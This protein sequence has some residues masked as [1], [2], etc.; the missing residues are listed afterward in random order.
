MKGRAFTV[1]GANA[2]L[3]HVRA[4]FR[5]I[6]TGQDAARR[7]ADQMAVLDA[8][9][10]EALLEPTNPDH[11]ELQAHR[12]ALT[13]I[14]RAIEQ[15]I[16]DRLTNVGIRLPVGGIDHGLVDFP[17]T[18]DGRWI[19]LCWHAGEDEVGYWHETGAGFGGRTLLTP[20]LASRLG[21][22]GDPALEDDSAL[23]F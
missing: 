17:S 10:G 2:L 8:L 23:D 19:Y 1:E 4:T 3:P 6:K 18:L 21:L 5:R 9:W 12:T 13:R 22:A 11:D 14:R 7:R 20:D 16:L 15:L